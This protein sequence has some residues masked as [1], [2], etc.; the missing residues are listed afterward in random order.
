[1]YYVY[2]YNLYT[3]SNQ[4][5]Y[6]DGQCITSQKPQSS[7]KY[8]KI[9]F[10]NPYKTS[11]VKQ[12]QKRFVTSDTFEFSTIYACGLYHQQSLRRKHKK[13]LMDYKFLCRMLF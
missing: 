1:M 5:E 7:K 12:K 3:Y 4:T 11:L 13:Y 10:L 2:I 8:W 6:Y 9:V